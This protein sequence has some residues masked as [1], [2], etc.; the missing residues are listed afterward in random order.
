MATGRAGARDG[1]A[2]LGLLRRPW[3]APS[4]EASRVA[5]DVDARRGRGQR[6]GVDRAVDG[7]SSASV[8]GLPSTEKSANTR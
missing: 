6:P 8:C 3:L 2:E 7:R 1:E 4:V 5:V